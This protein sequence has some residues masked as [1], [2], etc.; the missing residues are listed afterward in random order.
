MSAISPRASDSRTDGTLSAITPTRPAGYL[1]EL[2]FHRAQPVELHLHAVARIEPH[3][4]HETAREHDLPG[5]QSLALFGEMIGEPGQRV[6]GM[7]E[8]VGPGAAPGLLAVDDGAALDREQVRRLG[9]RHRLAEHAAGGEEIIGNKR[10]RAHRLPFDVAVVDD[11]DRGMIGLDRLH[12]PLRG[13][14]SFRW[15]DIA[16]EPHRDLAFDADTDIVAIAELGAA[17][18]NALREYTAA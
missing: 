1:R 10:R 2:R 12:H 11:L 7:T 15:H 17:V 4:F 8:H 3:G 9:A 13:E 18:A 14:R 6:V 16:C 5:M